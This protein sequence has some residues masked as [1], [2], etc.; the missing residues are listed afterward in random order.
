MQVFQ[1]SPDG[2]GRRDLGA[3][4]ACAMVVQLQEEGEE[5][6]DDGGG[7]GGGAQP[8]GGSSQQGLWVASMRSARM[9]TPADV[10]LPAN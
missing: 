8:A 3:M 6:E 5:A 1:L 10:V 9:Q 4:S 2:S 7:G